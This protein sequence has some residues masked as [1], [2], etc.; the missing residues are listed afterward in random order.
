MRKIEI[1]DY[2]PA[3][4]DLFE[5]ERKLLRQTLDG[6]VM[7]IHHI[8]STS[9]PGLAAKPIIDILIE[10]SDVEELDSYNNK[11][12][13]TGYEAMGEYGIPGRR[14]FRKGGENR[15]HHIHAFSAGD[16]NVIRHIAFRDYLREKPEVVAEYAE[17]KKKLAAECDNDIEKYCDGK[18][19]FVKFH[20]NI[21]VSKYQVKVKST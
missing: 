8:G 4:P 3:W 14:Y 1:V 9:V 7:K 6:L 19:N 17:L 2:N 12:L 15:T 11:M 18:E 10:V 13:L 5:A 16:Y 21:A 20:E